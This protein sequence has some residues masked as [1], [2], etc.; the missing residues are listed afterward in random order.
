MLAQET[1]NEAVWA[2]LKAL[3]VRAEPNLRVRMLGR[4]GSDDDEIRDRKRW[5]GFLAAF[6]DDEDVRRREDDVTQCDPCL[7]W[8]TIRV[9]D[10]A[11]SR[12]S[13]LLDVNPRP[14]PEWDETRW[15]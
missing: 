14:Q 11:A 8:G 6:L 4:F 1:D 10:F 13:E 15:V 2:A 9:G 7:Q 5:L 12:L 3:A